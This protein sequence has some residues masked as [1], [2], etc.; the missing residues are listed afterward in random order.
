MEK[1]TVQ[2]GTQAILT[3]L[4]SGSE[5]CSGEDKSACKLISDPTLRP[6]HSNLASDLLSTRSVLPYLPSHS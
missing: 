4:S 3:L 5:P 6:P 1:T 2:K